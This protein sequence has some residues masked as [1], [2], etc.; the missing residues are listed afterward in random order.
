MTLYNVG[1]R[2]PSLLAQTVAD[3][4]AVEIGRIEKAT[5]HHTWGCSAVSLPRACLGRRGALAVLPEESALVA[6]SRLASCSFV[7]RMLFAC[8]IPFIS[9]SSRV[10]VQR[11]SKI[12]WPQI[13]ISGTRLPDMMMVVVFGV[14]CQFLLF[15][16]MGLPVAGFCPHRFQT[17]RLLSSLHAIQADCKDCSDLVRLLR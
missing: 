5:I 12:N 3:A 11:I 9:R 6:D 10:H 8:L 16:G 15:Y 13:H 14:H 1:S 17:T 7:F 4:T 2:M